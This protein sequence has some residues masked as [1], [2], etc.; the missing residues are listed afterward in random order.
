M[1]NKE[2]ALDVQ[3]SFLFGVILA[4]VCSGASLTFLSIKVSVGV[5][6]ISLGSGFLFGVMYFAAK[7]LNK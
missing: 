5:G 7:R 4:I 6:L 1:P 2:I 3:A